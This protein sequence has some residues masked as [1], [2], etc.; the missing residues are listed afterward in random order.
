[1]SHPCTTLPTLLVRLT[2][3]TVRPSV[4]KLSVATI[5]FTPTQIMSSPANSGTKSS[6]TQTVMLSLR[7]SAVSS[8]SATRI[9]KNAN[10]N[11]STRSTQSTVSVSPRVLVFLSTSQECEQTVKSIISTL[12][13]LCGN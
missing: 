4:V 1:M 2:P 7:T 8:A 5:R 3:G 11:S 9:S 12:T 13:L 6:A 10:A